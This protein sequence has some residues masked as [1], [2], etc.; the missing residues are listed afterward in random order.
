MLSDSLL[1]LHQFSPGNI[2]YF[3]SD[4]INTDSEHSFV[5][6]YTQ[7]NEFIVFTC[8]TSQEGTVTD[9]IETKGIDSRTVVYI[10]PD[11]EENGL[12]KDT[13]INCNDCFVYTVDKFTNMYKAGAIQYRGIVTTVQLSQLHEGIRL[14][15]RVEKPI[16]TLFDDFEYD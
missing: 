15:K 1:S 4:Q 14:S 11:K 10:K 16:K 13:F 3:S 7:A 8:C 6:V 12:T 5:C 9:Y 2:Y